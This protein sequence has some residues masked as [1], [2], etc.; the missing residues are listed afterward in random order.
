MFLKKNGYRVVWKPI[1]TI[2]GRGKTIT[3]EQCGHKNRMADERKA[4]FDVEISVDAVSW[5]NNFDTFVLFSGDS[6]FVYLT[7][8]LKKHKK[9]VLVLSRRGH[10]ADELRTS[11]NIDHYQDV[12]K[13]REEFLV[14]SS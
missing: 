11:K 2:L 13:L 12:W 6:D 5:L 14:R 7:S 3:C 4:D 1:K 8:F 10:V 9:R